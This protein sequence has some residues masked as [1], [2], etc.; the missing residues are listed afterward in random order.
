MAKPR[1]KGGVANPVSTGVK[2]AEPLSNETPEQIHNPKFHAAK[3]AKG[4]SGNPK[5]RPKGSRNKFAEEFI[6]DFLADWE[7]HGAA[8]LKKCRSVDPAAY[9]R[10]AASL[11]PKDFNINAGATDAAALEKFLDNF[12][13]KEL[14]ELAAGLAA[15]GKAGKEKAAAPQ[16]GDKPDSLH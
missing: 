9:V 16:A 1:K 15:V 12:S 13:D 7:K 5:G 3:F 4:Q 11:L 8:T 2:Q 6:S 10:V 14:Q